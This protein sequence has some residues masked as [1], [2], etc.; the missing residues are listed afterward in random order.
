MYLNF[1]LKLLDVGGNE[2]PGRIDVKVDYFTCCE[3]SCLPVYGSVHP[4]DVRSDKNNSGE[5]N[6]LGE[7]ST[8]YFSAEI[9]TLDIWV[10]GWLVDFHADVL[11]TIE[12]NSKD[13]RNAGWKCDPLFVYATRRLTSFGHVTDASVNDITEYHINTES[14]AMRWKS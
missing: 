14:N 7:T 3:P 2:S 1:F 5:R 11:G 9:V 12:E 8:A 13:L 4:E 10:V 6:L